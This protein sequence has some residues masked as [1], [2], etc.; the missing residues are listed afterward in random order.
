MKRLVSSHR[1]VS[2]IGPRKLLGRAQ[3]QDGHSLPSTLEVLQE[4]AA[5][6]H[7]IAKG[8]YLT[9]CLVNVIPN[10]RLLLDGV[11]I[12]KAERDAERD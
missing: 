6:S 5:S 2:N 9:T 8:C 4:M 11:A 3:T 1:Y 12:I 10:S 7:D